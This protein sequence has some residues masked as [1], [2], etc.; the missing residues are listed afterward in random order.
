MNG[1]KLWQRVVLAAG[2]GLVLAVPLV[3]DIATAGSF[4][5][6]KSLLANVLWALLAAAFLARP[7]WDPWLLPPAAVAVAALVSALASTPAAA[8]AALPWIVGA[9]GFGALRQLAPD[10]RKPLARAVLWAGFLQALVAI[11]FFDPRWRPESFRLLEPG[12][13]RYL[14]LG[15]MGNPADVAS[16][17][18]LPT[19]LAFAWFWT[20]KRHFLWLFVA[21]LQTAVIVATQTLSALAALLAGL[22]ALAFTTLSPARRLRVLGALT[23]AAVVLVAAVSPIR[24]RLASSWQEMKSGQWLW[25]ASARGAA[26]S[27]AL[28]M[29]LAH[30][31]A[32]VGFGQFEAHSFRYLT[33][34][35]LAQ[36]S[37]FLGLE[38]GFGEAH[39]ELLQ[40]LAE[41]GLLGLGLL[42]AG[43][44]FALKATRRAAGANG[45][46]LKVSA[47]PRSTATAP[48]PPA[49]A[50]A[51]MVVLASFQFPLH[52]AAIAAQWAVV[53]AL[54]L[55]PLPPPQSWRKAG[56]A[57]GLA[58]ALL[59][60][61]GSFQQWRAY[62]AVQSADVL[63][64]LLR[65]RPRDPQRQTLA[66][67]AYQGLS[68]R[69][70]SLP[71]DYRGETSAGNLAQEAGDWGKAV[72]H[73]RRALALAE[74]P[75]TRFNLGVALFALGQEGE[76]LAHLE[77]AVELNP[78]VLKAITDT[79]LARKLSAVLEAHGYFAR[80]PWTREWLSK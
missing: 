51:S 68:S 11:A 66:F 75:E 18:V 72:E 59:V 15:T 33:A 74:R 4:R 3:V 26:W 19:V 58:C 8:W 36:R 73:F 16:F 41:T 70:H 38:T 53:A 69:L 60:A 5:T 28:R 47:N 12:E 54:L 62:R 64:N 9:L 77:R 27:S 35:E 22:A 55:P 46:A 34:D 13:G 67:A 40:Y 2:L 79:T 30:P 21:L 49:P 6:P 63:V 44:V 32:G 78:A 23:I 39:N 48:W 7:S 76:A 20:H 61:W 17:L 57:V 45:K 56:A 43:V 14:W 25:L 31:I 10:L 71:F 65:Q 37:R 24:Q 1:Q 50:L 29:F 80:F 42:L 52:L